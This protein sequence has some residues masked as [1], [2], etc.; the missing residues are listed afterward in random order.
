MRFLCALAERG[1]FGHAAESCGVTQSTFSG[2]IK[3]MEMRLGVNLV[4]RNHRQVMLTPLG[5]EIAARARRLLIDA[6]ELVGLAKAQEALSGSLRFGVIPTV[7]PYILPSLLPQL[8]AAL[9]KLKL[10]VREAQTA[11]LLQK[12]AEGELDLLFLAIPYDIGNVE[13]MEIAE[14]P[15]VVALPAEHPLV[16]NDV[17]SR[18]H[19]AHER[20]LLTEEGHCLR[21]HSLQACRIVDPVHNEILRASNLQ[22]LVQMVA[23]NVGITLVPQIALETELAS[24]PNV[25]IRPLAP[26]KP[27]RTLILAWRRRSFQPV[28]FRP[29]ADLIRECLPVTD[30]ARF[31]KAGATPSLAREARRPKLPDA[32]DA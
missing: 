8:K 11:L 6:E 17:V 22:T 3:E 32:T 2:G 10:Y 14:D 4:E 26:D 21:S 18:D 25:V 12:L 7:G 20:L 23:A 15:I 13:A 30:T 19:L 24:N 1:H 31:S 29:L 28:E 5:R 16:H 9:P 27:S